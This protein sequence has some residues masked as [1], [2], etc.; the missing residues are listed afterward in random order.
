MGRPKQDLGGWQDQRQQRKY[1]QP[2]PPSG[3]LWSLQG[4][5]RDEGSHILQC[6]GWVRVEDVLKRSGLYFRSCQYTGGHSPP[7]HTVPG[8]TSNPHPPGLAQREKQRSAQAD[9]TSLAATAGRSLYPE[10]PCNHWE[11]PHLKAASITSI[12]E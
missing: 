2:G 3:H 8:R 12:Q 10:P 7:T 11:V 1:L 4:Q 5:N 9:Q 6:G